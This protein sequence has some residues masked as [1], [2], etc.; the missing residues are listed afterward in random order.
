MNTIDEKLC[1]DIGN[2]FNK[3]LDSEVIT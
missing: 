2:L 3:I 1:D